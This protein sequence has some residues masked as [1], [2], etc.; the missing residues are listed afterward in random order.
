M[1]KKEAAA[2]SS[3]PAQSS[4]KANKQKK[5]PRVKVA[6]SDVVIMCTPDTSVDKHGTCMTYKDTSTH[7]H[8]QTDVLHADW[9]KIGQ[10][11]R[12]LSI[13]GV[14]WAKDFAVQVR[15]CLQRVVRCDNS[16]PYNPAR[17]SG[18]TA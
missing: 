3:A 1:Q 6:K 7:V 9:S 15:L 11:M 16:H 13:H 8:R 18:F 5:K 2:P 4:G 17:R 12:K 14:T 10:E